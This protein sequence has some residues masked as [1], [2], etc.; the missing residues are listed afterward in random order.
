MMGVDL[1]MV[2]VK[3]SDTEFRILIL[4]VGIIFRIKHAALEEEMETCS[5]FL[6]KCWHLGWAKTAFIGTARRMQLGRKIGSDIV[7]S[8][9]EAH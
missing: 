8:R 3:G 2:W 1:A 6:L 7:P 4:K 5:I 9:N